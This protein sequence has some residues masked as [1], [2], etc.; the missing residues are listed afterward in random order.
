MPAGTHFVV[1]SCKPARTV[2]CSV[3]VFPAVQLGTFVQT[4]VHGGA[5][6][7]L[8]WFTPQLCPVGHVPVPHG[9]IIP[10]HPSPAYPQ[11]YLRLAHVAGTHAC[12][13]ASLRPPPASLMPPSSAPPHRSGPP[14]PQKLPPLHAVDPQS[15]MFPQLSSALP[16]SKPRSLQDFD[17]HETT[18]PSAALFGFPHLLNPPTPHFSSVGHEPQSMVLPQPSPLMPHS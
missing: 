15:M 16:Q 17:V 13:P 18:P 14:P 3:V 10:P 2:P 5:P 4:P 7:T 6:Q 1:P 9:P 12:A 11:L 8:G